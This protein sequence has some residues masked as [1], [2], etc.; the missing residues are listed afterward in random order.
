M[1][2]RL[3]RYEKKEI[4]SRTHM[5]RYETKLGEIILCDAAG[6]IEKAISET[7]ANYILFGIPED[8]G[9]KANHGKGGADST[10]FPFL[11]SFL[12]IQSNDFLQGENI[13]SGRPF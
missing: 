1:I 11:E 2:S 13:F 7:R 10:W 3:K 4:L 5:R 12:N 6:D 9:V 8:I